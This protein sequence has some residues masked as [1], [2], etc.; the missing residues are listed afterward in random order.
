MRTSKD[1]F[2]ALNDFY[3]LAMLHD[4]YA[5]QL[6]DSRN[7]NYNLENKKIY[8]LTNKEYQYIIN[9]YNALAFHIVCGFRN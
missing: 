3:S 6:K 1:F 9:K 7:Y 5:K 4:N 8:N 2:N